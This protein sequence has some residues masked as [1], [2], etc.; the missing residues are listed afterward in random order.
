[1]IWVGGRICT[2]ELVRPRPLNYGG[3][4][5]IAG[6]IE[7][8][9]HPTTSTFANAVCP[10]CA[11]LCDDLSGT[12]SES[13]ISLK[14]NDCLVA[15]SEFARFS[16]PANL[17]PLVHGMP[18]NYQDAVRTAGKMIQQ[19][20]APLIAGTMT[21]VQGARA[22]LRLAE[23]CGGVID[24]ADNVH[25]H[26]SVTYSQRKGGFFTTLAEARNRADVIVIFGSNITQCA[27]RF[28]KSFQKHKKQKFVLIGENSNSD[29]AGHDMQFITCKPDEYGRIAARLLAMV[30][31][32]LRTGKQSKET[33][34][35]VRELYEALQQAKYPV[36]VWNASQFDEV[37][38]D[39][40][41]ATI[42]EVVECLNVTGR[43]GGLPLL[44]YPSTP[45]VNQVSTWQYGDPTPISFR[46]RAPDYQSSYYNF[47]SVIQRDD[48]DLVLWVGGLG[49][50]NQIKSVSVPLIVL[51]PEDQS[52]AD[53]FI[54][55]GVPGI[56]HAGHLFRMDQV[57][58]M[59]LQA[60][61][62][63]PLKSS[64]R[65]LSDITDQL[66]TLSNADT[67]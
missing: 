67:N 10:F 24:Q 35:Q 1:M 48:A 34:I 50:T 42:I 32:T 53:V 23:L 46:D 47:E 5:I 3:K 29:T 28:F 31:G 55:V 37:L 41:V 52:N 19:S 38:G 65:V 8:K 56:D 14:S 2:L 43:C 21:D 40:N 17:K 49:A 62:V 25:Y 61:R 60:L 12:V 20:R 4:H 39:G 11:L 13:V 9:S 63:S 66:H 45:T 54:P 30:H 57:V 33:E 58:P 51:A 7:K 27:P 18:S 59:F 22:A 36:I 64:A 16:E 15:N 26:R 44:R 6:M